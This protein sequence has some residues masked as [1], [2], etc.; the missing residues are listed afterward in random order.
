MREKLIKLLRDVQYLGGLEQKVADHLIAYKEIYLVFSGTLISVV[1]C[2]LNR[3]KFEYMKPI[4]H[5]IT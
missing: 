4:C 3:W 2:S 1:C 5:A